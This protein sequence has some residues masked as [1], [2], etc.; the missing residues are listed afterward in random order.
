MADRCTNCGTPI[1]AH[2]VRCLDC[3]R[4]YCPACMPGPYNICA[5][6]WDTEDGRESDRI[7]PSAS[8]ILETTTEE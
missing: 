2:W 7:N 1:V 6:C 3:N 5:A 4:I 8:M